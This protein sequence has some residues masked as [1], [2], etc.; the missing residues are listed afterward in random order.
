MMGIKRKQLLQILEPDTSLPSMSYWNTLLDFFQKNK[1]YLDIQDVEIICDESE[2]VRNYFNTDRKQTIT[3]YRNG[4]EIKQPQ[5]TRGLNIHKEDI[6]PKIYDHL[7]AL[8]LEEEHNEE[9]VDINVSSKSSNVTQYDEVM[10]L[11]AAPPK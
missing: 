2:K 9:Y 4:T 1:N 7:E 5:I 11:A 8:K 3:V 10:P 6:S